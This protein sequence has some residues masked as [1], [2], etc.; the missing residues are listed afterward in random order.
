MYSKKCSTFEDDRPF[1]FEK[2]FE[3]RKLLFF[4]LQLLVLLHNMEWGLKDFL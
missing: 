1:K 4:L 2:L 3:M